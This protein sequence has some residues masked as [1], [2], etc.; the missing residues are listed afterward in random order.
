MEAELEPP[1][2]KCATCERKGVRVNSYYR[3]KVGQCYCCGLEWDHDVAGPEPEP[4][5]ETIDKSAVRALRS[6]MQDVSELSL[7]LWN[8]DAL[9]DAR[10]TGSPNQLLPVGY[11]LIR[12]IESLTQ[13]VGCQQAAAHVCRGHRRAARL[14]ARQ[15]QVAAPWDW[16][17]C[18]PDEDALAD[19]RWPRR[20]G[21]GE[22]LSPTPLS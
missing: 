18:R 4:E 12:P 19:R 20:D 13:C 9:K 2:E 15:C 22:A 7:P 16:D 10:Y 11:R 21:G 17:L 1:P 6:Y 14:P 3:G 8:I 5:P